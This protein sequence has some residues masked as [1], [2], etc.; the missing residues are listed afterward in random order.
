[1]TAWHLHSLSNAW[2]R[3]LT[4]SLFDG[5]IAIAI[6]SVLWVA[7]RQ[8]IGPRLGASLFA[9]VLLKCLLPLPFHLPMIPGWVSAPVT[10]ASSIA[11]PSAAIPAE[12]ESSLPS[13]SEPTSPPSWQSW[14]M[15]IW[16]LGVALG[17]ARL[18][19]LK[20]RT[21]LLIQ[22]AD[23][24]PAAD[25]PAL[26]PLLSTAKLRS[27]LRIRRSSELHTPAVTGCVHPTLLL[28]AGLE[29]YLTDEQF[30]WMLAH[31]IA[32][33]RHGD[34]FWQ[35]AESILRIVLWHHP[36]VWLA[37]RQSAHLREIAADEAALS[38][39][40][41]SRQSSVRGFLALVERC[42]HRP[43]IPLTALGI[44]RAG[45]EV[46]QR[47]RALSITPRPMWRGKAR[48]FAILGVCALLL[49]TF[50]PAHS[51]P[52]VGAPSLEDLQRRVAELEGQL[53]QKSR[54]ESLRESAIQRA[55]DRVAE[56][57]AKFT[58]EELREIEALYQSAKR[59]ATTD[60]LATGFQPL[61]DRFPA[62]NRTGCAILLLARMKTGPE[63]AGL[64]KTAVSQHSD[65]WFLDGTRVGGVARLML[66]ADADLA[67]NADVAAQWRAE[68]QQNYAG[69]LDFGAV[70]LVDIL[71]RNSASPS[72]QHPTKP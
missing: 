25:I 9:L 51:Q 39:S 2:S 31:E 13:P 67:G 33:I 16:I 70:P 56:D 17:I 68:I 58:P 50:R 71:D 19:R 48:L 8:R 43:Q 40:G 42:R 15:T 1:M 5:V 65:A 69:D 37:A 28:P 66:A 35:W 12:P 27:P 4:D 30:R 14:A 61:F 49:P 63:R 32:H 38:Y 18:I 53:A 59:A 46:Q 57:E 41:A 62:A 21:N 52:A 3:W 45:R 23:E 7:M 10:A 29:P 11:A 54:L 47:I 44:G 26:A 64:L 24:I 60:D 6:A 20:Q 36:V 34:L 72:S 55:H 22:R